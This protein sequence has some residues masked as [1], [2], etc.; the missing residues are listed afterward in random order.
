MPGKHP[1]FIA[2]LTAALVCVTATACGNQRTIQMETT[3]WKTH[4][5]GRFLVDLPPNARIKPTY[6]IRGNEIKLVN[7]TPV[8]L[9]SHI[10]K[11]EELLKAQKH[12]IEHTMF[13]RRENHNNGSAT[14]LSWSLPSWVEGYTAES[15]FVA[16]SKNQYRVYEYAG[17]VE[18]S[19]LGRAL[20]NREELSQNIRPR[21]NV[22]TSSAP[23]YCIDGGFISGKEYRAESFDIGIQLPEH[24]GATI[25]IIATTQAELDADTLLDRAGA[26]EAALIAQGAKLLRKGKRDV[27]PIKGGEFLMANT[28]NGQRIYAFTWEAPGKTNSIAEPYMTVELQALGQSVVDE[29][30]PYQLPFKSDEEALQLWD[31]IIKSIRLRPGAA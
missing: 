6:K 22:D 5:I 21:E 28:E 20:K 10:T 15:Y 27:G 7:E 2:W 25:S 29:A 12:E 1:L 4:C 3:G 8:S 23:G 16:N 26:T 18:A 14:L 17:E 30:R 9:A 24:P 19:H 13:A 31:A 11:R